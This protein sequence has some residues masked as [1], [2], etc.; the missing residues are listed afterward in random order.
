MSRKKKPSGHQP[1]FNRGKSWESYQ[2]RQNIITPRKTILIVCEGEQTEPNYF[3]ALRNTLRKK[4]I[5]VVVVPGGERLVT[6]L[7]LV[8]NLEAEIRNLDWDPAQDEAWCVFD[9][10]QANTQI[11]LQRAI[12]L[13]KKHHYRL[14]LSNPVFEYWILLHYERTG[15]AF[16]NSSE[17]I[18]VLNRY[19][20]DYSKSMAVFPLI[21]G[22]T[23]YA[24]ENAEALQAN[25]EARWE[26]FPNPST[27][28]D[29]LVKNLWE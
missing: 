1:L 2:R 28:V 20:P 5:R 17:V 18:R 24:I 29:A 4:N 3:T 27:S 14:A 25:H 22:F 7:Y 15:R 9:V 23:S 12:D 6:P 8:Q 19:I 21:F 26:D 11:A 10:D 16:I 13:A